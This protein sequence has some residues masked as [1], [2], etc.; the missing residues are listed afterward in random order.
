MATREELKREQRR[1][2]N[3]NTPSLGYVAGEA[4]ITANIIPNPGEVRRGGTVGYEGTVQLEKNLDVRAISEDGAPENISIGTTSATTSF[5]VTISP[6]RASV[7]FL[8]R[9]PYDAASGAIIPIEFPQF[10]SDVRIKKVLVT[11]QANL[12]GGATRTVTVVSPTVWKIAYSEVQPVFGTGELLEAGLQSYVSPNSRIVVIRDNL[13]QART[14][15]TAFRSIGNN[16]TFSEVTK[17]RGYLVNSSD[18]DIDPDSTKTLQRGP[19]EGILMGWTR[20]SDG[21]IALRLTAYGP[22]PGTGAGGSTTFYPQLAGYESAR[23]ETR[24]GA[25]TLPVGTTR[26]GPSNVDFNVVFRKGATVLNTQTQALANTNAE[27]TLEFVSSSTTEADNISITTD[28]PRRLAWIRHLDIPEPRSFA[29]ATVDNYQVVR[30]SLIESDEPE[31]LKFFVQ[32]RPIRIPSVATVAGTRPHQYLTF[33]GSWDGTSFKEARTRCPVWI[34]LDVLTSTRFGLEIPDSRLDLQS[35]LTASRYAN[36]LINGKPR[37]AYDGILKGNQTEIIRSLLDLMN[38]ALHPEFE[39]KL[40]LDIEKPDSPEWL[41]AKCAVKRGR[42][43]VRVGEIDYS[44]PGEPRPPV[45]AVFTDRLT[46]RV[47]RTSG[48]DNSRYLEVPFQ[49]KEVAERWAA[50]R[51]LREQ[52]LLETVTFTVPWTYHRMELNDLCGIWDVNTVGIRNCG[53]ILSSG[54]T[55]N[56]T[57]LQLDQPPIR[58]WP[59]KA[60]EA[61]L[62]QQNARVAIDQAIWG[63]VEMTWPSLR[64]VIDFQKPNGGTT[65]DFIEKI[66]WLPG[67]RP[68]QNRVLLNSNRDLEDETVWAIPGSVGELSP[69]LWRVESIT[70]K[71]NGKEFE[72]VAS[73]YIA[74]MHQEIDTGRRLPAQLHRFVPTCGG[75]LSQLQGDFTDLSERY[76]PASSIPFGRG[77]NFTEIQTSC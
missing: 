8:K 76:I 14:D 60:A 21:R 18:W 64:P 3:V 55:G 9:F 5:G 30:S 50:W 27:Q 38:G 42:V 66:Q 13:Q 1:I 56:K 34:L 41:I 72:V 77:S 44:R 23:S 31:P 24:S 15:I 73:K 19:H 7:E 63:Y 61:K 10:G 67:G 39:A 45:R 32:G 53:K 69:T 11:L 59:A 35:F 65:R 46:G 68:E 2:V 70:E 52:E 28:I 22:G 74:G 16:V 54:K 43:R 12:S 6:K 17:A 48:L 62:V 29:N 40:A 33:S 25:P 4:V 47:E 26:L 71:N 57:W 37:L 49:D 75:N 51:N 20:E 58:F 36:G